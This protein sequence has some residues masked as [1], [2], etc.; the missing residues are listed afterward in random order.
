[1]RKTLV[2][3]ASPPSAALGVLRSEVRTFL[4]QQRED[5]LFTPRSD[6]WGDGWAPDFTKALADRGWVGMT[7]PEQY[8]G[9]GRS[10]VERFV[11]TEELLAAG[12]P[13]S[14]HWVAD[15]QAGPSLLKVG[16]EEQKA[17]YL[18]AIVRGELFFAIGMSEPGSGSD[19]AS[20]RTNAV[21]TDGGWRVSGT[22][23]WTSGA[24]R[25]HLVFVLA[26]SSPL[27]SAHRHSGLSQF[28]VELDAPGV[29][30]RPIFNMSGAHHFNEVVLENVFVP[31]G[32][33]LGEVGSG[34]QQVTSELGFERSGAERFLST[35]A[36]L[37]EATDEMADESLPRDARL[38]GI[39]ARMS[40][41][42]NM[43]FAVS[44]A[45][46][47]GDNAETAASL[48]KL[49]GTKFEGDIAEFVDDL[50]PAE[51]QHDP[52]FDTLLRSSLMNRPGFT[53]RGGTTEI[54]RGVVA[55]GL[56][57]R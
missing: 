22:K 23:L 36:L 12:A 18:P 46:E 53:I 1:M 56:G 11:V 48:V 3:K 52:E 24:H 57:M 54:M 28:I 17:R 31:D 10:F 7:I 42:H 14:A 21:R 16:T 41:L 49:V 6:S 15:R 40:A 30:I 35:F 25:A 43:S 4:R 19:L 37:A 27:D 8:G 13:V 55:R 2:P 50:N 51:A 47:R 32:Q 44:Q 33:V 5:G 34:W 26:R 29:E 38:G 20:V 9:P 39:V 45:L